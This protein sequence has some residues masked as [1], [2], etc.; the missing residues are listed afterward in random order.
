MCR[1]E[2][3]TSRWSHFCIIF[4]QHLP[5]TVPSKEQ[6]F[7][8]LWL[9]LGQS[10][11]LAIHV[12]KHVI[13]YSDDV[14]QSNSMPFRHRQGAVPDWPYDHNDILFNS[15]FILSCEEWPVFAIFWVFKPLVCGFTPSVCILEQL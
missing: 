12:I 5:R 14:M 8:P 3:H 4:G 1:N 2:E 6:V 15:P 9:F 13:V 7:L 10:S 11:H